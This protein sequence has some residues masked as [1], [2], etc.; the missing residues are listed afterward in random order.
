MKNEY[1]S[2]ND[3]NLDFNTILSLC[4]SNKLDYIDN[5]KITD[6]SMEPVIKH[7]S[8]VFFNKFSRNGSINED[9]VYVVDTPK[10]LLLKRII[11]LSSEKKFELISYNNLYNIEVYDYE[12]IKVL[13]K[14]LAVIG[15]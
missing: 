4:E 12:E 14:V 1:D 9:S 13:G 10:G 7:N 11:D 5:L 15:E 8:I 6:N 2:K 3:T